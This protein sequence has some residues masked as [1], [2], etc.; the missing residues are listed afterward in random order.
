MVD[1]KEVKEICKELGERMNTMIH[2]TG[3]SYRKFQRQ[4]DITAELS[5]ITGMSPGTNLRTLLKALYTLDVDPEDFF[6]DIAWK[7]EK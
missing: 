2:E 6:K 5:S 4:A 1:E 3:V 7:K